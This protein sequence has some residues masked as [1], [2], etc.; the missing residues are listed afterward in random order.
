MNATMK[1]CMPTVVLLVAGALMSYLPTV[2]AGEGAQEMTNVGDG[3][4]LGS[5]HL[6][7]KR[8][9]SI[10]EECGGQHQRW[11]QEPLSF[12]N[13]YVQIESHTTGKCLAQSNI[14]TVFTEKCDEGTSRQWWVRENISSDLTAARYRGWN[15]NKYL[16]SIGNGSKTIAIP[17]G[18][19]EEAQALQIWLY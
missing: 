13:R 7:D 12:D 17:L 2:S 1:L 6:L 15:N 9:L 10:T 11:Y 18:T 3:L 19:T 5:T 14:E 4:C 16:T 8:W